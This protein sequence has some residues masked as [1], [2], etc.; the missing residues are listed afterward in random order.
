MTHYSEFFNPD[1]ELMIPWSCS[2]GDVKVVN[3]AEKQIIVTRHHAGVIGTHLL[4][5]HCGNCGDE[6]CVGSTCPGCRE[7]DP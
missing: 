6:Y 3:H 1:E 5:A 2:C 7:C 4:A